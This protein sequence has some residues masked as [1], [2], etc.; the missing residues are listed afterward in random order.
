[1]PFK[2]QQI[3]ALLARWTL[4]DSQSLVSE[5]LQP[6]R[7][8]RSPAPEVP[9]GETAVL[10]LSVIDGIREMEQRGAARLLERLIET[11]TTTATKLMAH[12]ERALAQRDAV[13]LRHAVHTLKSSSANVGATALS[14]C[15]G[16]VEIHALEGKTQAAEHEWPVV[17]IEY[18]R[19]LQA[20]HALLAVENAA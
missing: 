6:A 13:M 2:L 5:P 12:A 4:P 15:F 20:L 14:Q 16:A 10:D 19:A 18:E 1:K 3:D 8:K 7:S 11:Y 17:R 9:T